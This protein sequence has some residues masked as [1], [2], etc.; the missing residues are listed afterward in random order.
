MYTDH[1]DDLGGAPPMPAPGTR[2][3]IKAGE[4]AAIARQTLDSESA[5]SR[6]VQVL[7]GWLT[8]KEATVVR[9]A[10]TNGTLRVEW[11]SFLSRDDIFAYGAQVERV[12]E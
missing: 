11:F 8:G 4:A 1:T 3:R 10:H 2:V 12:T 6:A 9:S 7:T 5:D